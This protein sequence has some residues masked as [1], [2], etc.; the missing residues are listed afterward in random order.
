MTPR[1]LKLTKYGLECIAPYSQSKLIQ[2]NFDI[3][4]FEK[5]VPEYKLYLSTEKYSLKLL[6]DLF[7]LDEDTMI[8]EI[9]LM[10]CIFPGSV[11]L[12]YVSSFIKRSFEKQKQTL[13]LSYMEKHYKHLS[14]EL[15]CEKLRVSEK[16]AYDIVSKQNLPAPHTNGTKT[17]KISFK[18]FLENQTYVHQVVKWYN[19]HPFGDPEDAIS[20]L[21]LPVTKVV[22]KNA[23]NALMDS[24]YNIPV[25]RGEDSLY[26]EMV[27]KEIVDY[28]VK[29]PH[30]TNKHLEKKFGVSPNVINAIIERTCQEWKHEKLKSYEFY[31]RNVIFELN[32]ISNMCIER[33][34]AS[35]NSSSRWL[36]LAQNNIDKKVKLL[37]LNAP[38]ELNVQQNVR[39]EDKREKDAIIE[40]FL[41]TDTIDVTPQHLPPQ[42]RRMI[43]LRK[44]AIES[45]SPLSD[46]PVPAPRKELFGSSS[47]SFTENLSFEEAIKR[48]QQLYIE[49][50]G[51]K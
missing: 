31:F 45:G 2:E 15:I 20:D 27:S 47:G 34:K 35:P 46:V 28:K 11:C 26:L 12:K 8:A 32:D 39:V 40:A 51:Y 38:L 23:L 14:V 37:G 48:S 4:S 9:H 22:L 5:R 41:A 17:A 16:Q 13:A 25:F 3:K 7:K 19:T 42:E 1:A 50:E 29:Y 33:F 24:G 49:E 43:E 6:M 44:D 30:V 21:K 36:E 10:T 18:A